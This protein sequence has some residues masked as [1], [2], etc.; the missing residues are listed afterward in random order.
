MGV[1]ALDRLAAATMRIGGNRRRR[2]SGNVAPNSATYHEVQKPI[3]VEQTTSPPAPHENVE[4][5]EP[6]LER[7]ET[8]AE[9]IAGKPH[10]NRLARHGRPPSQWLRS[11]DAEELRV[12]LKTIEVGEAGVSG[13]TFWVHLTR[14]HYFDPAKIEGLTI[15]EQALLHA[16]AH[17]GY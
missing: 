10:P 17:A 6:P 9:Q 15:D 14:D 2:P 11:L 5:V 16:A 7:P 12:W 1:G 4:K 3:V 13:M 8:E